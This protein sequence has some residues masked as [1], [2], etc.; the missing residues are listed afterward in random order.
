M[1]E[2]LKVVIL[3]VAL[4]YVYGAVVGGLLFVSDVEPHRNLPDLSWWQYALAPLALGL[5][6]VLLEA[7]VTRI[8]DADRVTDPLW[9]RA[10]KLSAM[11]AIVGGAIV[12]ATVLLGT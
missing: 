9:K 8:G 5:G 6:Y 4:L 11:L 10:I 12:G 3:G 1:L 7:L 2:R